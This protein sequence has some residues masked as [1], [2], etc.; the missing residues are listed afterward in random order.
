M[1]QLDP[2]A[3]GGENANVVDLVHDIV[4]QQARWSK[5]FVHLKHL[6]SDASEFGTPVDVCLDIISCWCRLNVMSLNSAKDEVRF[7]Q[8]PCDD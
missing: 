4:A 8:T 1:L 2:G 5:T 7:V 3:Y 6:V